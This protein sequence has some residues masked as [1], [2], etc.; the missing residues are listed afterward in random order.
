MVSVEC[1]EMIF[2]F[3]LN[4]KSSKFVSSIR[5]THWNNGYNGI[6]SMLYVGIALILS[7]SRNQ[8]LKIDSQ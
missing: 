1:A 4:V 8:K 6:H 3:I 7:F 5:E 2:S